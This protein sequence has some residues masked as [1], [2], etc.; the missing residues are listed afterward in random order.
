MWM[1]HSVTVKTVL[2]AEREKWND[3]CAHN[4]PIVVLNRSVCG[5]RLGYILHRLRLPQED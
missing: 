5:R 1:S 4:N 3:R 2:G